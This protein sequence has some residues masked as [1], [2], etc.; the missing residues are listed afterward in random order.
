MLIPLPLLPL[1]PLPSLIR[2]QPPLD[3]LMPIV[4]AD[5]GVF[6]PIALMSLDIQFSLSLEMGCRL[7]KGGADR[8]THLQ[9]MSL[10]ASHPP[11]GFPPLPRAAVGT[12][13]RHF[14]LAGAPHIP[15][16]PCGCRV[17]LDPCIWTSH[18]P[19]IWM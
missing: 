13:S 1:P 7:E 15:D 2:L 10:L 11:S 19:Q 12:R 17:N 8:D 18:L 6:L 16:V 14:S 3:Q 5:E 4:V 9:N